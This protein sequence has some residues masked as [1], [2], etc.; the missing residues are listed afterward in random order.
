MRRL[1]VVLLALGLMLGAAQSAAAGRS[2]TFAQAAAKARQ[3][4]PG[5]RLESCVRERRGV[6]ACDLYRDR[7]SWRY[8]RVARVGAA[9]T[10]A[11]APRRFCRVRG[12]GTRCSFPLPRR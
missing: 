12:K 7:G 9:R 3:A 5:Y 11:S 6:Y 1:L 2:P 10:R 8:R 4:A